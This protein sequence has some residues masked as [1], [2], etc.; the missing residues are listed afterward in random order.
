MLFLCLKSHLTA[1]RT[2]TS[3]PQLAVDK[4]NEP[5]PSIE[6]ETKTIP[7]VFENNFL[8][9]VTNAA[10]MLLSGLVLGSRA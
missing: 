5:C 3:F 9:D 1:I 2:A 4:T 7:R 8:H 10:A 6:P